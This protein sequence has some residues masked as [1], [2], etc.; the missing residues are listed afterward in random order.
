M[1]INYTNVA[2][3][4]WADAKNS[5]IICDVKF[6]HLKSVVP[7]GANPND[8]EAHARKIFR[9]CVDGKY[10][11]IQAFNAEATVNHL[12]ISDQ[13]P[14]EFPELIE[15]L[16]EANLENSSGTIRGQ[17]LIWSSILELMVT[18]LLDSFFVD[19]KIADELLDNSSFTFSVQINLAFSLGLISKKQHKVCDNVRIIRNHVA[20]NW[21]LNLSMQKLEKALKSL[22]D[23][24]HSENLI[25]KDD[26]DFLIKLVYSP[27]CASLALELNNRRI[28]LL[29]EKR[30][31]F[32]GDVTK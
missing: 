31:Q 30:Q 28:K 4:R 17:V 22:F 18:R 26:T 29:D 14:A 23:L 12:Q 2:N 3:P 24:D 9:E 16:K 19:H 15:L 10:G 13:P 5:S 21:K 27:S 25:W 1:E 32:E 6:D 11:E 20:H 8:N 7:F